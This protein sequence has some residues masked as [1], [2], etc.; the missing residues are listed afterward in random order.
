MS[1][2]PTPSL[3]RTGLH[4]LAVS[5]LS[6]TLGFGQSVL[7]ARALGDPA[8]KGGYDLIVATAGLFSLVLGLSLPVGATYAVARRRADPGALAK[9]LLAWSAAQGV[10]TAALILS[11]HNTGLGDTLVPASLGFWVIVPLAILVSGTSVVASL[12]SILFGEQRIIAANNGDLAGRL[13]VPVLMVFMTVS[14][15]VLGS[16]YLTLAFLWCL[17]LG[18]LVTSARFGW[19]LKNDLRERS[20]RAGLRVVMSFSL[21]SYTGNVVQFLNYR[22]DLFLVNAMVGLRAVGLYA[23][24][25]S[26]AQLLWLVS[27]SAASVLLPRVA[28]EVDA[29]RETAAVRSAQVARLTLYVTTAGAVFLGLCGQFFIPVIYGEKFRESL[30]PFL[31]LLP[32]ITGFSLAVVLASHIAG[33]GRPS[34]NMIVSS[35]ALVVT[36]MLDLTLIPRIGVS[37]A[38]IA[39]SAS[40]LTTAVVTAGIFSW[41]THISPLRLL[42]PAAAD[43]ALLRRLAGRLR[44][45]AARP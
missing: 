15:L 8:T 6:V 3:W 10:V 40:Y 33:S 30:Q 4:T 17:A 25:V 21:P 26:V 16:R 37:G 28:S 34:I 19:L 7:I 41:M 42:M 38:A 22:L 36:L 35:M 1:P 12:R 14:S 9:W 32:G 29:T 20:G 13:I 39:S 5:L 23:L 44:H 18:M 45:A 43:V 24:A 11:L 27:Q 2:A 31:L